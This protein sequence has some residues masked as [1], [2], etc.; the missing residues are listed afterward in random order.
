M[1]PDC[2]VSGRSAPVQLH[3]LAAQFSARPAATMTPNQSQA[4]KRQRPRRAGPLV[5]DLASPVR[6]QCS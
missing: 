1:A 5:S 2:L 4:R 3:N 6:H